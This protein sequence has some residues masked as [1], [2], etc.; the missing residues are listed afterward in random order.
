MIL[1]GFGWY[2]DFVILAEIHAGIHAH[3]LSTKHITYQR[4]SGLSFT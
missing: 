3:P 1:A 4:F 2:Y